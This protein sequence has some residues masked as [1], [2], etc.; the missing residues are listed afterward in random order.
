TVG[1]GGKTAEL[2]EI[3]NDTGFDTG[4]SVSDFVTTD[5][6]LTFTGTLSAALVGDEYVQISLDGVTTWI[7]GAASQ[8]LNWTLN[9][10]GTSLGL[11]VGTQQYS[12]VVRVADTAGNVGTESLPKDLIIDRQ[13]PTET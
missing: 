12:V 6:T 5:R 13:A 3:T 4:A 9:Y 7:V 8:G 2:V 1:V 10:T 11:L